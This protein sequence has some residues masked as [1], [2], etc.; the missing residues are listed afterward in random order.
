LDKLSLLWSADAV[1][2]GLLEPLLASLLAN[3]EWLDV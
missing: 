3:G 1:L 2:T